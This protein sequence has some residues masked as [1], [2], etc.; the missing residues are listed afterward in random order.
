[1]FLV[2]SSESKHKA[3]F[4]V[5]GTPC[6]YCH[7]RVEMKKRNKASKNMEKSGFNE[8]HSP[9]VR[10]YNDIKYHIYLELDLHQFVNYIDKRHKIVLSLTQYLHL[11][12]SSTDNLNEEKD[13]PV[14]C[15]IYKNQWV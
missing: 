5:K 12:L 6:L 14:L 10:G 8:D 13:L 15:H 4:E 7:Y 9:K 1:M 3:P 11:S 2:Q